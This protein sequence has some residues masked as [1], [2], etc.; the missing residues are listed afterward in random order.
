[1]PKTV[2]VTFSNGYRRVYAGVPD[3]ATPEQVEARA[4]RDFPDRRVTKLERAIPPKN[5][6][7]VSRLGSF[8]TGA[9]SGAANVLMKPFEWLQEGM[10]YLGAPKNVTE[11]D[12]AAKAYEQ[13]RLAPY[14]Q[15]NPVTFAAGKLVG[16]TAA[17]APF[18]R[19]LGAGA[20]GVA[21]LAAKAAPKT[22]TITKAL[23]TAVKSGGFKTGLVPTREA[24]KRGVAAAPTGAQR[25]ADI[26]VRAAGGAVTGAATAKLVDDNAVGGSIVGA[27]MP[28]A[29][30]MLFRT[31]GDKVIRPLWV[32]LK[33]EYGAERAAAIFR[34][35]FNMSVDDAIKAAREAPEGMTFAEAL[36]RKNVNEPTVQALNKMVVEGPGKAVYAPIAQAQTQAEQA[37]LNAMR[38]GQSARQT[39]NAMLAGKQT[40]NEA[41]ASTFGDIAEKANLGGKVIPPAESAA[42]Q[43]RSAAADFTGDVRKFAPA[44]ERFAAQSE[45]GALEPGLAN[46]D[47]LKTPEQLR[48]GQLASQADRYATEQ[49]AAS[50]G[51]G[52]TARALEQQVA[53]LRAAGHNVLQ[54]GPLAARIRNMAAQETVKGVPELRNTLGFI[55]DE[56]ERGGPIVSAEV[57][58]SIYKNAGRSVANFMANPNDVGGLKKFSGMV[59]NM[60]KP[61]ITQAIESAGGVGYGALKGEHAGAMQ[62]LG[63]QRFSGQ[64]SDIYNQSPETFRDV[65]G[66][67]TQKG[68]D[69]VSS[70]FP[71]GG[72]RN[73]DIT[74]MMDPERMAALE[75]IAENIGV[76][77]RMAEQADIG[78]PAAEALIKKPPM[79]NDILNAP[80]SPLA[81]LGSFVKG[82]K[83]F[84][85]DKVLEFADAMA[86]TGVNQKTQQMLVEGLRNGKSAE[87]LLTLLPRADKAQLARRLRSNESWNAQSRLGTATGTALINAATATPA[88][89]NY[90]E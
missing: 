52:A 15:K 65:V 79:P 4:K 63:R 30:S 11:A 83:T 39:Q 23:E 42:R 13:E 44:A 59:V 89:N 33:G 46:V 17:T 31:A 57:L 37:T 45:T 76:R 36:A 34:S 49:A 74:A 72:P 10:A 19:V 8:T 82:V 90:S 68:L 1:M 7:D 43:M 86:Q 53:D 40:A 70:A 78:K 35:A 5:P 73:F 21:N 12:K 38:G 22:K 32:R 41:Y 67:A 85:A 29:G 28:T 77:A 87:A 20:G 71:Q 3:N 25:A 9:L 50:A 61:E 56:I 60:V 6:E 81:W 69:V 84:G 88:E 75:N 58:D 54:S 26:A 80:V 18:M 66:G 51:A 27:L 16:E 55:A 64:L 2:V 48:M 14:R 62:E 24:I 47:F